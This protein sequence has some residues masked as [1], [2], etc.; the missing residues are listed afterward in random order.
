MKKFALSCLLAAVLAAGCAGINVDGLKPGAT[1]AE[2]RA[3]LGTERASYA[4]PGG[5]KRLEFRG[6]GA[7][8]FMVDFD[9]AGRMQQAVQVLNETNFRNI[10]AGM[11]RDDVLATLG[12]PDNI[13]SG[14]RQG[15][16]V[17]SWNFRNT[18]C[19]WFQVGIGADGRST[20]GGSQALLPACMQAP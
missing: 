17:L 4:L 15:G 8:T 10:K 9:A 20:S 11:T 7:Q 16:E 2:V 18:Q 14:G 6:S 13:M 5:A 19:Q 3:Q 12:Q 1:Q